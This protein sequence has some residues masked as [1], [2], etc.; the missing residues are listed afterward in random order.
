MSRVWDFHVWILFIPPVKTTWSA[1]CAGTRGN[2]KPTFSPTYFCCTFAKSKYLNMC[3]WEPLQWSGLAK[4][5]EGPSSKSEI[6]YYLGH[7]KNPFR[8][9][10]GKNISHNRYGVL[11]NL[12]GTRVIM[13]EGGI[14]PKPLEVNQIFSGME[15]KKQTRQF[16]I[17][18]LRNQISQN[19][20]HMNHII[21]DYLIKVSSKQSSGSCYCIHWMTC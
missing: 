6:R 19:V 15:I 11:S 21:C 17:L 1:L 7:R 10:W 5:A 16:F 9:V 8:V 20:L 4:P 12:G 18:S 14:P 13:D 2:S 3:K